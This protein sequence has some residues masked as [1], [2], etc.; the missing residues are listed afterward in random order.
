MICILKKMVFGGKTNIFPLIFLQLFILIT[1]AGCREEKIKPRISGSLSSDLPAQESW[2]SEIRFTEEG[3]LK[4]ILYTQHLRVFTEKRETL[5]E[6]VK[7]DFYDPDGVKTTTLTSDKGR[8][9]DITKNMYAIGNVV[10]VSDS[11][12]TLTT[13]ELMWRNKDRKIVSDKFVTIV[14]PKEKIQG[15]GFEADQNLKNYV[16]YNITFITS[17]G[18]GGIPPA[19]NDQPVIMDEEKYKIPEPPKE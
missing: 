5:L 8:V 9:D 2:N 10:A 7:I 14:S 1:I 6:G 4:G 19:A 17:S 13:D 11:G 12:V 16:I 18:N 3:D 15:Y